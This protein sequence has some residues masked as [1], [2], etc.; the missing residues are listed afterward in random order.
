MICLTNGNITFAAGVAFALFAACAVV[1]AWVAYNHRFSGK[2]AFVVALSGMLWWLFSVGFDLASPGVACKVFWSL[3]AW[4]AIAL[5]PIAWA[6]FLF[7][8]TMNTGEGRKPFRK[9]LYFG[10]PGLVSIIALTNDKTHLLYGTGLRFVSEGPEA[11]VIFD[12]GPLF[13][14][15]A[16]ALY[17]FVLGGLVVLG[18]AF[19]RAKSNIKSFLAVLFFITAAP[20]TANMAY[21]GWDFTFFGFDPTPFMFAAALIGI[22]WLLL[23][24]TLMDTQALGRNLLFYSTHDPVIILD[25]KC[26]FEGANAAAKALFGARLPK[27]GDT[28]DHFE[29][30]AP[31]LKSLK[32]TGGLKA[33]EPIRCD[34]HVFAPRA[35]AIESPIQVKNNLLGWSISLIDITQSERSAEKLRAAVAYAEAANQAKSQFLAVISHELRTP[36]T[37]VKGGLDLALRAGASD[38]SA[39]VKNLLSIAQRNSVRLLKLVDDVL[40]LQK[41][42]L[43]SITLVLQELNIGTFLQDI[44]EEYESFAAQTDVRIVITSVDQTRQVSADPY[45]LKQVVGNILSNAVKFSPHG[46]QVDC[47]AQVFGTMLRLSIKDNGI[48]IP[49]DEEHKVFGRFG[50]VESGAA[51]SYGGSGLGM[52][53]AKLLIER[54]GG[55]ISYESKLGVGTVFY[56]DMPLA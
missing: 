11:Y 16:A 15:I 54:M 2:P 21:I 6:F 33:A 4:P 51:P 19:T 56:V 14:V 13:Y 12:H 22:S 38:M 24:N 28:M 27:L 8:Y 50:Q 5:V 20:L 44:V 47:A 17:V 1:L 43:N 3:A 30:L 37:S 32:E 55:D 48:G 9:A 34:D 23:N 36:M 41:L 18:F 52:H 29:K 35:L 31:L 25:A 42:E 46:G 26:R 10:I 39:P 49:K 45:R 40:D 53:I 7:D